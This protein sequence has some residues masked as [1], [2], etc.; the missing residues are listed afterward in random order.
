MFA[1]NTGLPWRFEAANLNQ[2]GAAD[3]FLTIELV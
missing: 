3:D 1:H 2:N